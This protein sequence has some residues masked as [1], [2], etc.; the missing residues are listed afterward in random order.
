VITLK[1]NKGEKKVKTQ[2]NKINATA[3]TLLLIVTITSAIFALPL[4]N[5]HTPEWKI[6]TWAY[7]VALPET[8]GVGQTATIYAFLGNPPPSGATIG[9]TYRQHNYQI[10]VTAPDGKNT[11]QFY[12]TVQDTTCAQGYVFTPTLVGTY[13][14]TFNYL[15]F[16]ITA[17][18]DQPAST[19]SNSYLNDTYLP[20]SATCKL[21]VQQ[22]K[23]PERP[24]DLNVLPTDYWTRPIYGMNNNWYTVSS[25]WLGTGSAVSSLTGS[26]TI[27]GFSSGSTMERHTGDAIGPETSHIMWTYPI[28]AGGVVGGNRSYVLGNT[29]FEGSAYQ[30]RFTNPIII[31]GRLYYRPPVSFLGPNSGPTVCQDLR[32][33]QILWN[34]TDIPTISFGY[35][36][37]LHT[38]NQHGT[39]PAILFT[40]NFARAFDAYTG[41]PLFNVTGV[42]SGTVAQGPQGEQLRYVIADSDPSPTAV[43]YTLAQWNSTK[44]WSGTAFRP[45]SSGN[46]PSFDTE[47]TT[48][49]AWVNTT[50]YINN[51]ITI[52]SQNVTTST[53]AINASYSTGSRNRN[54]WNVTIP[55]RNNMTSTPTV[56]YA[57]YDN[58][59]IC[60]NGSLPALM[61][62]QAPYTYFAVSLKPQ[63][64]GNILWMKT[65][66]PPAG[67]ITL[68]AG[69]VDPTVGVFTEGYKETT[70]W[71]GYSMTDGS[72]LW[73]TN[74]QNALDYFGSGLGGVLYCYNL[75]NGNILWTYGNGGKGNTTQS[76]FEVPGNYPIFIN[77][78]GSN[79]LIYLVTTE[80]TI[81]TPIY[82]G[83][84]T[85][86]IN[87][88]DGKEI[89]ALSDYTGEF[90]AMSYA[91][92]DGYATF[93]NGYDDQIYSVGRG[94]SA[95]TVTAP[96]VAAA[97]GTPIVIKGF[98]T[99]VSA[100]TKQNEQAARFPNGVPVASD[101]SMKEWMGY[102]YQQQLSPTNFTGVPV[103]IDIVDSNGNYRNIGTATTDSTG[104]FHL[105]WT[106]DIP[107]D[108]TVIAT[109][110]GTNGY[111]PSHTETAFTVLPAPTPVPVTTVETPPDMTGTYVT[112]AA[113][114]IIIA[115][116]IV[117]AVIVL[118]LRKRP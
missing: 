26:G 103:T 117:G 98:V 111:W 22:D 46:S 2:R 104:L 86:C 68:S 5:A 4:A 76:Y 92:A 20:S 88:T 78:V 30:Q 67:N 24:L 37:D 112:Y 90:S 91:I 54:D 47:T 6:P 81:Q 62:S 3:I 11:T 108:Y 7:V 50:T 57:F 72:K 99:D 100:G 14:V 19:S 97:F 36:Y 71:A 1:K 43:N 31:N 18:R 106:P 27:T 96:D 9:N 40:S 73:T 39:Y 83:A 59:L 64:R 33:G 34:R 101:A 102:V 60:R 82:K 94:P 70:Q 85:R 113:V 77:A 87:A 105:T 21:F 23:I 32:T 45:G 55:W 17:P 116:A 28:E 80:H 38:P 95:T 13:D 53:T 65:Y 29:Y 89:W 84:E 51:S 118:M 25:D 109:F 69:P 12:E 74:G 10:I 115:V 52:T 75:T 107:S 42:P 44:M 35:I 41:D 66:D 48:T 49:W 16:T 56:L 114:A 15:G 61:G 63:T 110:Q 93:Y 58:M 79:G 8:V